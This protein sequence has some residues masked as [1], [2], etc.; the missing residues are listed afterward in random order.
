M[1]L[2]LKEFQSRAIDELLQATDDGAPSIVLKSCTGSGKTI[3][4]THFACDFMKRHRHAVT[5][6]FTPGKG[7]LEIQS[8]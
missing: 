6:W 1:A 7:D 5:I 8:K 2:V 3:I 4:L